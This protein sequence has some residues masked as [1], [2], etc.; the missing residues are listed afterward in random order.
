MSKEKIKHIR[1]RVAFIVLK[2]FTV[3][4]G[5][6]PP[7][8]SYILGTVLGNLVNLVLVHHRKVSIESLSVA[9]PKMALKEKRKI[10]RDFFVFMAQGGLELLYFLKNPR[11]LNN[12]RIEGREHLQAA[13]KQQRGVIFLTAHLGNFPLM[14][15]KLAKEGF[16][17]NVVARPMRDEK[18]GDYLH[19][20]RTNSGVKTIFS[21]PRRDCVNGII[22]A[23][24]NNECVLIQMDQ[25]FGTGGVWVKFFDKLAATPVGPII[26]ALRTKAVILPSYIYREGKGKHC[27]KI[28]P[29]ETLTIKET[30]EETILVNA[31][32]FTKIIEQWVRK[33][34][35]QWGWI[36]RRWK[37]RPSAKALKSEFMIEK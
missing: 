31:I 13:L 20:L 33:H 26:F 29:G 37:S 32:K 5:I 18:A 36:H 21:Y 30:K 10:T 17:V 6:F 14:S 7:G 2:A 1:R 25:N 8:W 23:L 16:A 34:P 11:L 9:F 22:K 12:V 35:W 28:F 3:F 4:H 19:N 27:M 15:L 24:R